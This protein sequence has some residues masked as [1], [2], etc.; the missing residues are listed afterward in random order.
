[1]KK[2]AWVNMI[3]IDLSVSDERKRYELNTRIAVKMARGALLTSHYGLLISN[4]IGIRKL[5]THKGAD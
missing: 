1:M 2:S 3:L 5:T 4:H